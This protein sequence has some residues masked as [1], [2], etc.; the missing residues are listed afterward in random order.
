MKNTPKQCYSKHGKV[1][2]MK[3]NNNV[4]TLAL[5]L[6]PKAWAKQ[7]KWVRTVAKIFTD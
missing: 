3:Q 7:G 4:M 2:N 5:A 6:Q 1:G